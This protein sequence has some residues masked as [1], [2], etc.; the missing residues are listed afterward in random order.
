MPGAIVHIGETSARARYR[1][2]AAALAAE[3]A[4]V[5]RCAAAFEATLA[6]IE[7]IAGEIAEL[8][9]AMRASHELIEVQMVRAEALYFEAID[10]KRQFLIIEDDFYRRGAAISAFGR[11]LHV[12]DGDM[13][14]A[15]RAAE[16]FMLLAL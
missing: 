9:R 14:A 5:E 8:T 13:T 6:R 1:Q 7:A 4:H 10:L 12:M 2:R 15:R 16:E 3:Q 11:H